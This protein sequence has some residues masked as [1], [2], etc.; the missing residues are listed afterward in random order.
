MT[1][2][3]A[4]LPDDV[5]ALKRM[6]VALT[7]DAGK[8]AALIE[9]LRAE[10]ARLK[11]ARFGPSSEKLDA[12]VGEVETAIEALEA[13]AAEQ[14]RGMAADNKIPGPKPA[15]RALRAHLP[16]EEVLHAGPCACPACGGPLRRIGADVTETLD[17]AQG[18]SKVVSHV[19]EAFACRAC[20][21]A[22]QGPAPF[23]P[24]ARGRAGRGCS[25]TS[26]CPSLTTNR[27]ADQPV[28][29]LA[30]LLPWCWTVPATA[31]AA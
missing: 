16:R 5:G 20:D 3:P 4:Q 31:Q 15:R 2:D 14:P 19:L 6:V 27:I 30:D 7:R 13:D 22:L 11:R 18:R 12:R 29:R 1:I 24:I 8:A 9:A 23:H 17:Y 21:T 25:P 10:L 26:R 28:S